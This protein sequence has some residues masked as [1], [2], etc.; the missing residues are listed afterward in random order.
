MKRKILSLALSLVMVLSLLPTPALAA[1]EFTASPIESDYFYQQLNTRAQKIYQLILEKFQEGGEDVL[2]GT[3]SIELT[4][5]GTIATDKDVQEYLA[6]NK[7]LYNDFCAAKDALDLD[8]SELWWLD[9]GYMSF[10]ATKDGDGTHISIGP[11]RGKNYLLA[12]QE[13]SH[14]SSKTHPDPVGVESM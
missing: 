8:H 13:I 12:G 11:G 3:L 2:N 4:G 9:S 6:G 5:E 7:D 14:T 1:D 10:R